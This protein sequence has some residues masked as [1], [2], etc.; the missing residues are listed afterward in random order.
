MRPD[1]P[2]KERRREASAHPAGVT[3]FLAAF[4]IGGF[5]IW[6]C[7]LVTR[8]VLMGVPEDG[9]A[10]L[11]STGLLAAAGVI[12]SVFAASRGGGLVHVVAG[13]FDTVRGM[14]RR[15]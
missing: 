5:T 13:W 15:W 9:R 12:V 1:P 14:L 10:E 3:S 4:A 8:I 2:S 6:L 11:A 7:W